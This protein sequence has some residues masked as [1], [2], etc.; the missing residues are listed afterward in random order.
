MVETIEKEEEAF[1]F[2]LSTLLGIKSPSGFGNMPLDFFISGYL[3]H[4]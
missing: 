1:G 3:R 2:F 4:V